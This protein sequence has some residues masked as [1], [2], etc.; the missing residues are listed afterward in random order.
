MMVLNSPAKI[1]LFLNILK[2]RDDGYHDI[3]TYFQFIDLYDRITIT[4]NSTNDIT[5]KSNNSDIDIEDN[6]CCKAVKI[7][8]EKI[9]CQ[10]NRGVDIYLE[11]NI[12]IGAGLGGGSSNAAS[13][14]IGLN[15]LW[16]CNLSKNELAIMGEKLGADV[17]AFINGVPAYATGIGTNLRNF[18][19]E[20]KFFLVVYPL[21]DISTTKMYQS[22]LPE[23]LVKH[24]NID[25]MCE[26]IGFNSFEPLLCKEY[27]EI[28][29]TLSIMRE[30]SNGYVSGS[31]SCL[32]SIFDNEEDA[33]KAREFVSKSYQT[34]IVHSINNI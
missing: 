34:Y 28:K 23:D 15:K 6:L 3:Q 25:N 1:N 26:N 24:I 29:E 7:L 33:K 12:P 19:I 30:N 5:F 17:P 32:F 22:Y 11:K 18:S 8:Q 14:L 4:E 9:G 2:K 10:K 21:I 16:M 27:P 20:K 31:G 13:I